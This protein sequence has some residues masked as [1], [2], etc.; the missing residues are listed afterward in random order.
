MRVLLANVLAREI[1]F[2]EFFKELFMARNQLFFRVARVEYEGIV[3]KNQGSQ[4][5]DLV[6]Y[7][8]HE[9]HTHRAA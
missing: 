7:C 8:V 1:S 3:L 6:F 5:H 9:A 4:S 2:G